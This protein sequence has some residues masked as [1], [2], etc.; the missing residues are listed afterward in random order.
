[1]MRYT[2][3]HKFCGMTT[4]IE[5]YTVWDAFRSYNKD[6]KVWEVISMEIAD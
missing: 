2:I 6:P 4:T 1:M 5:G 3:T